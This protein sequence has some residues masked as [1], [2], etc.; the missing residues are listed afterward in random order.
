MSVGLVV[1]FV[2]VVVV[3]ASASSKLGDVPVV[4]RRFCSYCTSCSDASLVAFQGEAAVEK[5]C[6]PDL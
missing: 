4:L 1:G 2:V 3:V 6:L 5:P